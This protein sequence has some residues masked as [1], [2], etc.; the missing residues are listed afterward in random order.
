MEENSSVL[1]DGR[2]ECKECARNLILLATQR[3]YIIS[4]RLEPEIYNDREIYQQLTSLTSR[5]RKTDI[6]IVA[7]DTRVAANQ[8]HFLIH[9]AQKLPTFAQIRTTVTEPDRR[10]NESWLIVDDMAYMRIK[11]P[12]RFEGYS[13][14]S[15]KLECRSYINSFEKIWEASLV[16]QNTRRLGI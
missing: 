4:Q 15:N 2:S 9:L 6:R 12:A 8:G 3:V 16:D 5:N 7:H 13:E 10:F 11:D 14:S 1:L